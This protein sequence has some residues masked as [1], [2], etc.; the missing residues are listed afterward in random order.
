MRI[1]STF[2]QPYDGL[3]THGQEHCWLRK[4]ETVKLKDKPFAPCNMNHYVEDD[5]DVQH[6]VF[7]INNKAVPVIFLTRYAVSYLS[8]SGVKILSQFAYGDAQSFINSDLVKKDKYT[9]YYA[10]LVRQFFNQRGK[11]YVINAPTGRIT[12]ER[13]GY[14]NT[15]ELH[16]QIEP[17][18]FGIMQPYE[19]YHEI[20]YWFNNRANPEKPMIQVSNEDR[21]KQRGFDKMSFR[22]R[23]E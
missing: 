3:L 18:F 12:F 5:C 10:N 21:I 13:H 19:V 7:I 17:S 14:H 2:K 23:K 8:T 20:L 11:D 22:K 1:I 9:Y 15:L 4:P 16:T 6:V